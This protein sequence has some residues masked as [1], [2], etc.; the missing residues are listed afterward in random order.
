MQ[1]PK[2]WRVT[3]VAGF[4]E[5]LITT[6]AHALAEGIPRRVEV[7]E[8]E[9]EGMVPERKLSADVLG[10]TFPSSVP[11]LSRKSS[12]TKLHLCRNGRV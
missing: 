4:L 3:N 1:G 11:N 7:E 9:A 6:A 2:R 12:I 5:T 10:W 8:T